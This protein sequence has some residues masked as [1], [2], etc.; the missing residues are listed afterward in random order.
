MNKKLYVLITIDA[1]NPQTPLYENKLKSNFFLNQY[2]NKTIMDICDE[3]DAKCTFFLNVYE[4]G[5]WGKEKMRTICKNIYDREFDIQLHTHPCWLYDFNRINMYEYSFEEQKN[6]IKEGMNLLKEFTGEI[7]LAHRAGAYGIN[8]NT[9]KALKINGIRYDFSMFYKHNN[10]KTNFSI[11]KIIE[12]NNIVEVP[13]TV[14][15]NNNSILKLDI[16]WLSD[17]ELQ[18][19][20]Y[21]AKESNLKVVTLFMHSYSYIK[22]TRDYQHFNIDYND[23]LKFINVME[24]IKNDKDIEVLTVKDFIK[25]CCEKKFPVSNNE[26]KILD[27]D[28]NV[29]YNKL[30]F[31]NNFN[32]KYKNKIFKEVYHYFNDIKKNK[33]NLLKKMFKDVSSKNIGIYGTGEHTKKMLEDYKKYIGKIDFSI[34]FFNSNPNLWG[35]KYLGLKICNTA[36]IPK[37]NL[38]RII[39]SSYEFQNEIYESIKKYVENDIKIIK[40]YEDNEKNIFI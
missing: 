34:Y 40:I 31:I 19:A 7:P 27:L 8:E 30:N 29:L 20:I 5:K 26:D 21:I 33:I 12:R 23:L 25:L 32:S 18:K 13:V 6:I 22:Y 15:K 10:C 35:T 11:N 37:L 14:L 17:S 36:E 28:K 24:L 16:D 2:S 3:Y 38:D 4:V 9:L 1:E 39:I